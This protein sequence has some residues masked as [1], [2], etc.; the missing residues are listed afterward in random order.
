MYAAQKGTLLFFQTALS[1]I[2]TDER[3]RDEAR[4][5]VTVPRKPPPMG[6]QHTKTS[7]VPFSLARKRVMSPFLSPKK[8]SN[9]PFSLAKKKSNVPF[10]LARTSQ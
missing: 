6:C 1:S 8:K 2:R 3:G 4:K 7:N 9:V 5:R 10:S